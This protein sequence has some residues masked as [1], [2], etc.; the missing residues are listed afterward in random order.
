MAYRRTEKIAARQALLRQT[1]LKSALKLVAHNGFSALTIAALA[2]TAGVATGTVYKYF[3]S[4]AQ[5][6]AEVFRM[7]TEREV[8]Q[9]RLQA[10]A[11][12]AYAQRL[13][14]AV[15][16][17]AMRALRGRRLAYALIAEPVDPAVDTERLKYR[18]AYARIFEQ[19][20]VDGITAG[21]FPPQQPAVS[22]AALVGVISE[23]M[24]G[25]LTWPEDGSAA[26]LGSH[27][28]IHAIQA[29]CLRAVALQEPDWH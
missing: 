24:V 25:P 10:E 11:E 29:F 6:C 14:K 27:Q 19:L 28:L 26:L 16:T 21:E 18:Q 22:A 23:A 17:F 3:D 13:L 15:E 2:R 9:V 8:E 5:L 4:K 7:A 12:G 20:V 1:L